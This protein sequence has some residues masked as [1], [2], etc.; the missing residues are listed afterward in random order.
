MLRDVLDV[1]S[2]SCLRSW[3]VDVGITCTVTR[4]RAFPRFLVPVKIFSL[5]TQRLGLPQQL[6]KCSPLHCNLWPQWVSCVFF[7]L[8]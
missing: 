6:H 3:R 2:G 1:S 7:F 5:H 4:R 8:M